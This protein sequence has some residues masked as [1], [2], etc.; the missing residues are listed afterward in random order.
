MQ[1]T[2]PSACGE[3]RAYHVKEAAA[4]YRLSRTTLYVLMTRGVLRSVKIGGRRLIPADALE[5][6][7]AVGDQKQRSGSGLYRGFPDAGGTSE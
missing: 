1:Q 2:K 7:L 5:S 3:R 4:A 6:L